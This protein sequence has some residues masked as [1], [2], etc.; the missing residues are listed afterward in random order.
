V[1]S[2]ETPGGGA[3]GPLKKRHPAAVEADRRDGYIT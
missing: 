2:I 3:W 1:L